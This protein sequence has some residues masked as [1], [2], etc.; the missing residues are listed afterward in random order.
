MPVQWRQ[1]H[2]DRCRCRTR[3]NWQIYPPH[4][5][6]RGVAERLITSAMKAG[7]PPVRCRLAHS[8][9][10]AAGPAGTVDC[11]ARVR[12]VDAHRFDT[13]AASHGLHI[14][15]ASAVPAR[16][17]MAVVVGREIRLAVVLNDHRV[18]S[19]KRS[20]KL[21]SQGLGVERA[22]SERR[23][24]EGALAAVRRHGV[25][26][27]C[28][29]ASADVNLGSR[30]DTCS[31]KSSAPASLSQS[32][33]TSQSIQNSDRDQ[34]A[35]ETV[36]PMYWLVPA[37]A[38]HML[39][40]LACHAGEQLDLLATNPWLSQHVC[41]GEDAFQPTA[42]HGPRSP[43]HSSSRSYLL[44]II[45]ESVVSHTQTRRNSQSTQCFRS[46]YCVF[47]EAVRLR[48][49]GVRHHGLSLRRAGCCRRA[50]G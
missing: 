10:N 30:M 43:L 36:P 25:V 22:A 13:E 5:E 23:A 27:S 12:V 33:G 38:V 14:Q 32:V 41:V 8:F 48:Q 34:H 31:T 16:V 4:I 39:V 45:G 47:A 42:T 19:Q 49:E 21:D 37:L 2:R 40:H 17:S 11:A 18:T 28:G 6:F 3:R 15:L 9:A 1:I 29:Q 46:G 44:R 35:A 26:R 50:R 7:K 24:G 20:I